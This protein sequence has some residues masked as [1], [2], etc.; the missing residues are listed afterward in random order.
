MKAI[1]FIIAILLGVV[2][3]PVG[4]LYS[5]VYR[6]LFKTRS[7]SSVS[8][9]FYTCALAVDQLGNVF[10]S[11]LFNSVFIYITA[12]VPFGDPDQT[13]SAVLGYAQHEN[14]LTS[15]GELVANL[16]DAI[17]KEHCKKAMIAD[18]MSNNCL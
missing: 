13:I 4:L 3:L 14:T 17:D 10:C 5:I 16:L 15:T 1:L 9:Y 8:D 7:T 18:I 12:S 11:D 2:L 6:L